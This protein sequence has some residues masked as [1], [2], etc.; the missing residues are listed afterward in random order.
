MNSLGVRFPFYSDQFEPAHQANAGRIPPVHLYF[1]ALWTSLFGSA[2]GS[3]RALSAFCLA[4]SNLAVFLLGRLYLGQMGGL[5]C[6]LSFAL[7]PWAF[8]LARISGMAAFVPPLVLM[9]S[10]VFLAGKSKKGVIGSAILFSLALY[11][12]DAAKVQVPLLLGG[13]FWLKGVKKFRPSAK[14]FFAAFA[15]CLLPLVIYAVSNGMGSRAS[16]LS[17]FSSDFLKDRPILFPFRVFFLNLWSYFSPE[18]LFF[19]GDRNLRHATQFG[20]M[21]SVFDLIIWV[22]LFGW[23]VMQLLRGGKI[24]LQSRF[25]VFCLWGLFAG[26]VPSALT[27]EGQPHA[28]RAAGSIGFFSLLAGNA[29]SY[30]VQQKGARLCLWLILAASVSF[31]WSYGV[32]YFSAYP[33]RSAQFWDTPVRRLADDSRRTGQWET[34]LEATQGYPKVSLQ[35]YLMQYRGDSCLQS[36]MALGLND[37]KK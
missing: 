36:R 37:S 35:Y 17:I 21:L 34:F 23:A 22:S 25:V 7:S 2:M 13:L 33:E 24:S 5:F 14:I 29:L 15:L 16:H 10:Y 9:G 28:L 6:A 19:T 4:I 8:Q 18:F 26:L 11:S 12:Y 30:L 3:V 1:G 32:D 20:G 31:G 27:W